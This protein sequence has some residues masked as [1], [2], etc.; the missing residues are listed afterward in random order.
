MEERTVS[1]L[2]C[3]AVAP[4][5]EKRQFDGFG[6]IN[7]SL[8]VEFDTYTNSENS[9]LS[10]DHIAIIS[11]GSA[12]HGGSDN[13]AGPLG[14]SN[15]E[16]GAWHS[17]VSWNATSQT[18]KIKYGSDSLTYTG[19]IVTNLF[20]G[21]SQVFWGFTGATGLY[22]NTQKVCVNNYPQNSTQVRDTAINAG[23]SVNVQVATG[24]SSYIWIPDSSSEHT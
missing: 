12:N 20:A 9:D 13:L 19:D 4:L 16:D 3:K 8:G 7:N 10:A 6:G 17:A 5:P 2:P 21:N 15:T 1:C 22:Y 23:T 18:F 11:N 14:L 24:A